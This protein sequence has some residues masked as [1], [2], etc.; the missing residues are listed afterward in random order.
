[1]QA[2]PTTTEEDGLTRPLEPEEVEQ[3]R[4]AFSADVP[5]DYTA[6]SHLLHVV[7]ETQTDTRPDAVSVEFGREKRRMQPGS[8]STRLRR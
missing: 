6:R 8:T 1:M 3:P 4:G 7:F 2:E 5:S